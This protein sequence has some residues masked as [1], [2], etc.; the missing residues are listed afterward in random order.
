MDKNFRAL[1]DRE[2]RAIAGLSMGVGIALNVGLNRLDKFA[3][4]G[5][6]SSGMFGGVDGV[7]PF[8]MQKSF[9]DLLKIPQ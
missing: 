8:D 5:E 9:P 3:S 6:F 4:V 2:H 7:P 1:T